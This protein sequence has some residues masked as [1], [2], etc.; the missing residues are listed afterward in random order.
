MAPV[1]VET[2][3]KFFGPHEVSPE[4]ERKVVVSAL[5]AGPLT[6]C[7]FVTSALPGMTCGQNI[8]PWWSTE[9]KSFDASTIT[10]LR[11]HNDSTV[12]RMKLE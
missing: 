11:F 5:A 12:W 8:P 4:R 2:D 9:S 3:R 10:T 1:C 6:P 7:E